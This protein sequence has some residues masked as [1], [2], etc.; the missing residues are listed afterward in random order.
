MWLSGRQFGLNCVCVQEEN[1]KWFLWPFSKVLQVYGPNDNGGRWD[2]V[3][4]GRGHFEAQVVSVLL[5]LVKAMLYSDTSERFQNPQSCAKEKQNGDLR[6]KEI[7]FLQKRKE[8][9]TRRT[10]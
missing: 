9:R 5:F 8:N 1:A 7:P 3:N 10:L 6:N 2:G 4:Y